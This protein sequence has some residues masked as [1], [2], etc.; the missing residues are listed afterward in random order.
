MMGHIPAL[1]R[2]GAG[3]GITLE[4]GRTS[5]VDALVYAFKE[6]GFSATPSRVRPP[7]GGGA[8]FVVVG[9]KP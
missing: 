9:P 3:P 8:V 1:I 2:R 4:G 7:G 5:S 6:S